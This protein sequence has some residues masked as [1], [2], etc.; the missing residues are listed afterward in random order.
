[1]GSQIISSSGLLVNIYVKREGILA[2]KD[3]SA[4]V[5]AHD[6][7]L[8]NRRPFRGRWRGGGFHQS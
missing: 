4:V 2:E 7:A 6:I 5:G 8:T 3:I 1:M